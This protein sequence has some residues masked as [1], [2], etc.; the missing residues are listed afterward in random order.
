MNGA[1]MFPS[2][3]AQPLPHGCLGPLV[4]QQRQQ[5]HGIHQ[6][7]RHA[8]QHIFL[9]LIPTYILSPSLCCS[10]L[11]CRQGLVILP[12]LCFPDFVSRKHRKGLIGQ[13]VGL[14][15][16]QQR[17]CVFNESGDH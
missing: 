9:L 5:Y 16:G 4:L 8:A 6:Q 2:P 1:G 17:G 7:P 15:Q 14:L 11:S 10:A 3:H 12:P 13:Q